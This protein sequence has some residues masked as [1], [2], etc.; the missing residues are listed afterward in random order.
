MED[1]YWLE[2]G[3]SNSE[4][5]DAGES[6][7]VEIPGISQRKRRAPGEEEGLSSRKNWTTPRDSRFLPDQKTEGA[8]KILIFQ[9]WGAREEGGGSLADRLEK[10]RAG[11]GSVRT[12]LRTQT[13]PTGRK[14]DETK[15]KLEQNWTCLRRSMG[16]KSESRAFRSPRPKK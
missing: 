14:P 11:A 10:G 16:K 5:G 2:T 13:A 9:C 7:R 4:S 12:L 15:K 1:F 3:Y 6:E 8:Q